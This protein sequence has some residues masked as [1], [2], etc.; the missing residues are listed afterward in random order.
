MPGSESASDAPTKVDGVGAILDNGLV[1][2]TTMVT[3]GLFLIV[4]T[5]E[6]TSALSEIKHKQETLSTDVF[7]LGSAL[8]KLL[9]VTTDINDLNNRVVQLESRTRD[10]WTRKD[11]MIWCRETQ[12]LNTEFVCG[13]TSYDGQTLT[14]PNNGYKMS[15]GN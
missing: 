10:R 8:T 2:F 6:I 1:R 15:S 14:P 4:S 13:N 9:N 7:D 11:M 5:Y 3:V 12:L